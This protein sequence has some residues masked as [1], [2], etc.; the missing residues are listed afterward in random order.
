MAIFGTGLAPGAIRALSRNCLQR[1]INRSGGL[2]VIHA[3]EVAI[4][5]QGDVRLGVVVTMSTP[6]SMRTHSAPAT[7][8]PPPLHSRI[9]AKQSAISTH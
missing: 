3:E 1:C 7:N 4:N 5:P 2:A 6:A 9:T 8:I